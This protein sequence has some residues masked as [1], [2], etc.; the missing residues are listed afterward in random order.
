[1]RLFSRLPHASLRYG[2]S[3]GLRSRRSGP[4]RAALP[5][6]TAEAFSSASSDGGGAGAKGPDTSLFVPLPVAPLPP[7]PEGDV[8]AE[9]TRPLNKSKRRCFSGTRNRVS[10][11][12][13]LLYETET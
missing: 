2:G 10:C 3:I 13:I 8:G 4:S 7:G 1:M 11:L 6:A 12:V 9:L 5:Q